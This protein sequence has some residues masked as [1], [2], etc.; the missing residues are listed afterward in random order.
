MNNSPRRYIVNDDAQRVLVGL[1]PQE[2]LEFE[3]LDEWPARDERRWRELY[4]KHENAWRKWM[5][6]N[7]RGQLNWL[8]R[9]Q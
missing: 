4:S 2:T 6:D 1:T 5:A 9:S 3:A 8:I 7:D